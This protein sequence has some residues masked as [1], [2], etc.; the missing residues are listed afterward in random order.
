ME[1]PITYKSIESFEIKNRGKV[2]MVIND[3]D[4]FKSD[5]DLIGCEVIIDGVIYRVKG[6]ESFAIENIK[7]GNPIGLLV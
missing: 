4:R 1:N 7:K 6:I 2:F 5:N 3:K